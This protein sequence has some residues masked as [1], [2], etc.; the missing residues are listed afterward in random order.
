MSIGDKYRRRR[1]PWGSGLHVLAIVVFLAAACASKHLADAAPLAKDSKIPQRL[2]ELIDLARALSPEFASDALLRVASIKTITSS[3]RHDLVLEAFDIA[4]RCK[5][6]VPEH[7]LPGYPVDTPDGHLGRAFR[8]GL[9]EL[10]LKARAVTALL[11]T[12]PGEALR[13]FERMQGVRV[14]VS[15]CSRTLVPNLSALYKLVPLLNRAFTAKQR[16]DG[17]DILLL[18]RLIYATHSPAQAPFV[19]SLVTSSTWLDDSQLMVLTGAVAASLEHLDRDDLTFRVY[20]NDLAHSVAVLAQLCAER[21]VANLPLF[22]ALRSLTIQQLSGERCQRLLSVKTATYTAGFASISEFLFPANGGL[23]PISEDD[24]KPS[25]ILIPDQGEA[26]FKSARASSLL[27]QSK[28]LRD[29]RQIP[30]FNEAE[31]D[32]HLSVFLSGL[33]SWNST[34]EASDRTLFHEKSV[35]FGAL[36]ALHLTP[37]EE[38]KVL[39]DN[40]AFLEDDRFRDLGIEWFLFAKDLMPAIEKAGMKDELLKDP[41]LTMYSRLE[42]E[43]IYP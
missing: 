13:L 40:L 29:E 34:E 25:S 32:Q 28:N 42:A 5:Y 14:P 37:E 27:A 3:T 21:R 2:Q 6:S 41:V 15:S 12:D 16:K 22:N 31:W 4:S 36:L 43:G 23:K 30:A 38:R 19:P 39:R 8:L 10:S 9:D 33:K 26:Y 17:D 7:N 24:L 35:L 18:S 11:E 1:A 20:F